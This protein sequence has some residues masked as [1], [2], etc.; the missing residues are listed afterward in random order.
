MLQ[1]YKYR[2]YPDNK[3]VE[4]I[5][6]TMQLCKELHNQLLKKCE[7]AHKQ[8]K[9]FK[10]NRKTLN[11]FLNEIKQENNLFDKIYSQVL[12][13]VFD[14]VIKSY[15]NFFRRVKE[16][17]SGKKIEAGFPR[18]KRFYKS[19]TYPQNNGSFKFSGDKRLY[20][21]NIGSIPIILHRR[22]EGKI[23][24]LT[25]KRNKAWQYFAIFTSDST[26]KIERKS[27][28]KQVGIDVGLINYA[29]LS[30]GIK[31][32]NPRFLAK[33]EWLMKIKQRKISNK[34]KDS[35]NK[36]KA[37]IIYARSA[38]KVAN[39]RKDFLHKTSINIVRGYDLIAVEK[40]QINDMLK[41]KYLSKSISDASWNSF[42]QMLA[43]KAESA[44]VPFIAVNSRNTTQMCSNCSSINKIKLEDRTYNCTNC[45]LIIDRD[46]NA[47]RNILKKATDGLSGS[48]AFGDRINTFQKG[49]AN[50]VVE[51]GT[52]R[53]EIVSIDAGSPRL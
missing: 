4:R 34:K 7:E 42:L 47:S 30:D 11:N 53:N 41:N 51:L 46:I 29:T 5:N 39:Q 23:K 16:R 3:R 40:L 43:Y 25:I 31:I 49:T 48:N 26:R 37:K 13:N 24:T 10:V 15:K 2:I 28:N 52:K 14:R 45:G 6:H 38:L 44:N 50:S 27:I 1:T 18:E 9:T 32:E 8:D 33:S 19:I 20:I 12:Q 36:K 17:K 35:N 21:S 22:I